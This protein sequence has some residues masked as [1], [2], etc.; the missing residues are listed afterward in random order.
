LNKGAKPISAESFNI[1]D[2]A[3][4]Q[5]HPHQ[6]PVARGS[7]TKAGGT[8]GTKRL[9]ETQKGWWDW[10]KAWPNSCEKPFIQKVRHHNEGVFKLQ[11]IFDLSR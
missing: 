7:N 6:E 3:G 2:F 1:S 5:R 8:K 11:P 10:T 4:D 9:L